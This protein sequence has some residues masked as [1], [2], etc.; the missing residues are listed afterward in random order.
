MIRYLT[1]INANVLNVLIYS[2]SPTLNA[3][4]R[5]ILRDKFSKGKEFIVDVNNMK[6]LTRAKADSVVSPLV[7]GKWLIH[8]DLDKFNKKDIAKALNMNTAFGVT[9]FWTNKY[10]VYKYIVDLDFV[11]NMNQYFS[12]YYY[13]RLNN[14]DILWLCEKRC[15]E[16]GTSIPYPL[17]VYLAENYRY[18]V[19]AVCDLFA[20]LK[21]GFEV[22]TKQ[23]VIRL[24]GLGGNSVD[25][26]VVSLLKRRAKAQASKTRL[27]KDILKGLKDLSN[28][29]EYKTIYNYMLNFLDGCLEMKQ[30][31]LQGLYTDGYKEIPESYDEKRLGRLRRHEKVILN[32]ISIPRILNLKLALQKYNDYDKE[33]AVIQGV[34]TYIGML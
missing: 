2:N 20:L 9:V 17:Q 3:M 29:L 11:K 19:Q 10:A 6:D 24:I 1:N 14:T 27:T 22:Q 31:Q 32:E 13:G 33:L 4:S 12:A 16:D 18:D 7:G 30:L 15:K 34:L 26:L 5:D 21:V 23:D 8:V 25:R 28:N